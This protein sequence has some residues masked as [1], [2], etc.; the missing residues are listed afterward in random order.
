MNLKYICDA[1][2]PNFFLVRLALGHML[3]GFWI[4]DLIYSIF[5]DIQSGTRAT[6]KKLN[7][8]FISSLLNLA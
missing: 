7:N 6:T 3:L 2:L 5:L 8:H 4:R 1:S